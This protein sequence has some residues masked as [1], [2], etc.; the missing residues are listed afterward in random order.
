[1]MMAGITATRIPRP[2]EGLRVVIVEDEATVLMALDDMLT[3]LGCSVVGSA[4]RMASARTLLARTDF[5]AA[6]LDLNLVGERIDALAKDL[7]IRHVPF[8]FATGYGHEDLAP[9]LQD[10]ALVAKPYTQADIERSLLGAV[11][12]H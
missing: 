2:L 1:M 10:A 11:R 9:V 8:I 6:V 12:A 3:D 4:A 7:V 5:D